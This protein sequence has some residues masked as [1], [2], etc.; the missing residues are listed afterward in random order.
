MGLSL[1]QAR[2]ASE[3]LAA[4]LSL[5]LPLSQLVLSRKM[6]QVEGVWASYILSN[7]AYQME[8]GSPS[9][10]QQQEMDSKR[11][12]CC[13]SRSQANNKCSPGRAPRDL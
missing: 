1:I 11:A 12:N 9:Q 6:L 5:S 13:V 3:R 4:G 2:A 10:V 8:L 7:E